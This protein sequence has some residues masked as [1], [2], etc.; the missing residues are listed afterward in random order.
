MNLLEAL[1]NDASGYGIIMPQHQ[2]AE[3]VPF[4]EA[5]EEPDLKVMQEAVGGYIEH[6]SLVYMIVS[7]YEGGDMAIQHHRM[8]EADGVINEEGKL[9]GL[10]YNALATAWYCSGR[11]TDDCIVGPMMVL[12]GAARMK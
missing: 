1:D 5:G 4:I 2:R 6:V 11:A 12:I 3:E 8:H 7:T 9:V 10:P